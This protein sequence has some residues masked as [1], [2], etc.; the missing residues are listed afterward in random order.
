MLNTC[1]GFIENTKNIYYQKSE[2]LEEMK[3]SLK[4]VRMPYDENIQ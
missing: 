2:N 1:K 3:N 4:P